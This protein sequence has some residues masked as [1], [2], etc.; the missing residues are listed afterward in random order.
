MTKEDF[1]R[2]TEEIM[3]SL[4]FVGVNEEC[5]NLD[6][7]DLVSL[8]SSLG[9]FDTNNP[10]YKKFSFPDFYAS[11]CGM[12]IRTFHSLVVGYYKNFYNVLSTC[13]GIKRFLSKGRKLE[14]YSNEY[15]INEFLSTE[16]IISGCRISTETKLFCIEFMQD[17]DIPMFPYNVRILLRRY[18]ETG[19][20]YIIPM[21]GRE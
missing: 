12:P 14:M 4:I 11:F 19:K 2:E 17:N 10:D 5:H 20:F 8:V 7:R 15:I 21:Q 6:M 9:Y 3:E 16:F 1:L 13:S 18:M